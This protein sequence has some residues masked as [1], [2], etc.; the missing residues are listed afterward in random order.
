MT[1]GLGFIG[2]HL[3][4]KLESENWYVRMFDRPIFDV[5][6]KEGW[7]VFLYGHCH[8]DIDYVFHLAGHLDNYEK[9]TEYSKYIDINV[10]SV[11][12]MFEVIAEKQLPIKKIIVA[13]SQSVYGEGF[14]EL[15]VPKEEKEDD[16]LTPIS[17]YGASKAAMEDILTTLGALHH[18]P[19]AA[20]R[21]SIVLG[22]GQ[23][24]KDMDSRILPCFV[25]MAKMGEIIT[26]EDGKQLRDFVNVHDVVDATFFA[27]TLPNSDIL[28]VGSGVATSVLEVAEY[29]A[30]KF[31]ASE[32]SKYINIKVTH[33]G[34][35]RINTARNQIMNI[36]KIRNLGWQ[37]RFT[38]KDA[39]DEYIKNEGL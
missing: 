14:Y 13:S 19:V 28:N 9:Q 37:P 38:W 5:T 4:K 32:Y 1:G 8:P 24:Y 17:M 11:A 2:S 15:D 36:D 20:L 22:A 6:Q 18:I 12:L 21:Y 25:E 7:K 10:K 30:Q 16:P 26:H 39:V 31:G 27:A 34:E 29:I 33:S 23:Q 3:V 35:K